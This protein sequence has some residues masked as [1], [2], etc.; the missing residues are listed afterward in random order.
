MT[1]QSKDDGVDAVVVRRESIMGGL[2]IIQAKRYSRVVGV[3]HIRELAGAMEEKKA[4]WRILVTTSWFTSGCHQKARDHGRME[5]IDG[6]K[7]TFLTKE[8][9]G[10]DVLIGIPNRPRPKVTDNPE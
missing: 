2:S 7:L 6:E 8:H 10:K 4:G 1:E 5:L 3:N 9:L